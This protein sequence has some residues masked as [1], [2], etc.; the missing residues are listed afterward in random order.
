MFEQILPAGS[1]RRQFVK[2]WFLDPNVPA[3]LAKRFLPLDDSRRAA[4]S[5][6]LRLNCYSE[7][8]S[9]VLS[10][11][12]CVREMQ[13]HLE[14]RL[15]HDRR[16]T[17]P[18][19]DQARRLAGARVLEIGCGT[20]CSTV[21]L[22]EQGA[23]VVAVDIDEPAMAVARQRC[24]VYGLEAEFVACSAAEVGTRLSGRIF[25]FIIFWACLEHLT[26]AERLA[27]MAAT[28]RMLPPGGLWCVTDTPNRLW[29][30][31][32]HTSL[33][34]F[35]MWLPDRLAM[36]YA[37]FSP[38]AEMRNAFAA[39]DGPDADLRFA[40]WGRGASFHEFSLAMEPAEK[41]DV[42]SCLEVF[43]KSQ[44]MLS[45]LAWSLSTAR[46]YESFLK[47]AGPAIHRGFYQPYLDLIIRKA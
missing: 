40:R 30:Y 27:S 11:V 42:V 34:P 10:S 39:A 2:R 1:Q 4:V 25:D 8:S 35:F 14:G 19:L 29:F 47:K 18:W 16:F 22:A 13:L 45:R 26:I 21:A 5:D 43:R 44:R 28:W 23:Q 24:Q 6:S 46:R 7:T 31:D 38:R 36:Q 3:H 17:I 12:A 41:L 32:D 37:Q 20:G 9:E 15:D 33:L